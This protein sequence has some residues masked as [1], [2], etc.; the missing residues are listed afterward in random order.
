MSLKKLSSTIWL[1]TMN[2][3]TQVLL[4]YFDRYGGGN[5]YSRYIIYVRLLNQK[6]SKRKQIKLVTEREFKQ[7]FAI[8]RLKGQI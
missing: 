5:T 3:K 8:R 6:R 2:Q 4:N 1:K 7:E